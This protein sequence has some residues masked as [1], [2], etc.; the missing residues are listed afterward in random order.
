MKTNLRF[1]DT[2]GLDACEGGGTSSISLSDMVSASVGPELPD[3][4]FEDD[5]PFVIACFGIKLCGALSTSRLLGSRSFPPAM[6]ARLLTRSSAGGVVCLG[7][8]RDVGVCN[9]VSYVTV[10][11]SF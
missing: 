8:I 9:E 3:V 6:R 11:Y 4:F 10:L 7:G 1:C 5:E 2:E